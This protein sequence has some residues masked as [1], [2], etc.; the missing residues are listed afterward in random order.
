[1]AGT[2]SNYAFQYP[3]SGDLVRNGATAIQTLATGVDTEIATMCNVSAESVV[4]PGTPSTTTSTTFVAVS[5]SSAN[6]VNVNLGPSGVA[7]VNVNFNAQHSSSTGW[8]AAGL[9]FNGPGVVE[10]MS[11]AKAGIVV[12]T[13]QQTA[14]R[15][16]FIKG[17][18]NATIVASL[19]WRVSGATGTMN[20][21]TIK[22]M[23]IG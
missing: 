22:Y 7:I 5:G 14:E 3:T 18:A 16:Y 17:T 6:T 1:M 8:V 4:A 9:D 11:Q 2:T 23:T 21:S 13:V 12:G 15:T 19:W 10:P 20:S